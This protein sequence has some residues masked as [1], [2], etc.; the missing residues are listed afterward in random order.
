[1]CQSETMENKRYTTRRSTRGV[2]SLRPC[3]SQEMYI[4]SRSAFMRFIT[5]RLGV[6]ALWHQWRPL[7]T[8]MSRDKRSAEMS[9]R[10]GHHRNVK[11]GDAVIT[12]ITDKVDDLQIPTSSL[13]YVRE[14]FVTVWTDREQEWTAMAQVVDFQ[15]SR[16]A[17]SAQHSM[18]HYHATFGLRGIKRHSG[19][20]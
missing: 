17:S 8:K 9:T 2:N 3:T 4:Q 7:Q 14:G 12:N 13:I 5:S 6:R 19:C 20:L 10:S 11:G 16:A 15:W 1:M 18:F